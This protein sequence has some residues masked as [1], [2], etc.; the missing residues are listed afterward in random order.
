MYQ[1]KFSLICVWSLCRLLPRKSFGVCHIWETSNRSTHPQ[2]SRSLVGRLL[3]LNPL[4]CHIVDGSFL[5]FLPPVLHRTLQGELKTWLNSW[6]KQKFSRRK[7]KEK[8]KSKN[9]QPPPL[10]PSLPPF[11]HVLTPYFVLALPSCPCLCGAEVRAGLLS[12]S[13]GKVEIRARMDKDVVIFA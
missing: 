7:D 10:Q 12:W 8:Y 13:P 2:P 6:A 9:D 4:Q 3:N 1:F 5:D 11:L